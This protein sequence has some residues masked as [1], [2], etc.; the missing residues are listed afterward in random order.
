[1]CERRRESPVHFQSEWNCIQYAVDDE[2][3]E[4]R[5]S[6]VVK[7]IMFGKYK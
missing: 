4:R 3:R 1:M 6:F 5:R 2:M 7:S